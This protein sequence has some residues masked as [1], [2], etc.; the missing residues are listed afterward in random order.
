[1]A[2]A[3]VADRAFATC[4]CTAEEGAWSRT[5]ELADPALWGNP[6]PAL[7]PAGGARYLGRVALAKE[8]LGHVE[9]AGREATLPPA[10]AAQVLA[11]AAHFHRGLYCAGWPACR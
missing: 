8:V 10:R 2:D 1:M 6:H 9:E 3:L 4:R 11:M 5:V 7:R